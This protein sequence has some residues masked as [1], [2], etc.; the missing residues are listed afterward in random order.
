VDAVKLETAT[1]DKVISS[2]KSPCSVLPV[3][4]LE[5]GCFT[6]K[7]IWS[8]NRNQRLRRTAD[9]VPDVR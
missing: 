3:T 5:G 4:P 8:G 2:R 9:G 1:R 7:T 6:A